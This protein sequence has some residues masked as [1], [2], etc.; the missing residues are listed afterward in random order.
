[1]HGLLNNRDGHIY[2]EH[3]KKEV[4]LR[5]TSWKGLTQYYIQCT[6][7]HQHHNAVNQDPYNNTPA[8]NGV[9]TVG[10]SA[11]GAPEQARPRRYHGGHWAV[12]L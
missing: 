4:F 6:S 12:G 1:M 5:L 11:G 2:K 3:C 8:Q 7:S 10:L 9:Q